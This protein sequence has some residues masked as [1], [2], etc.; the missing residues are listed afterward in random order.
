VLLLLLLLLLVLLLL[1]LWIAVSGAR[2]CQ[3]CHSMRH[4]PT[5]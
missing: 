2:V 1:L 4:S 5:P 3:W